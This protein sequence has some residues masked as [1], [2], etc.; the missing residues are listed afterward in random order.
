[1]IGPL[2]ALLFALLVLVSARA[3]CGQTSGVLHIRIVVVDAEQKVTPVSRHTLL[4]SE[5]PPSAAPRAIVT[6][7]DGTAEV[8]LRPGNYTVESERPVAFQGRVYQWTRRIDIAAGGDAVLE[9]TA[10]NADAVDPLAPGASTPA[11][12]LETDPSFLLSRWQGSVVAIWSPTAHASGFVV[13]ARGLIATNQKVIGTATTVEVQ[14][15]PQI[16]IPARVLVAD[17]M[18]DVAV[19]LVNPT[20][21]ASM[22]PMPLGCAQT[23]R[24]AVARDQQIFTI[25]TPLRA[26]K[27]MMSGPVSRVDSQTIVADFRLDSG[28]AGGPVFTAEG[29]VVG[30]TTV[31]A[32][33]DDGSRRVTRAVRLDAVCD[34]VA[35]A[36]MKMAETAPPDATRLPME[37]TRPF[38]VNALKEAAKGRA[39]SLTPPL[40]PSTE[41]DV[42]FITPVLTYAAQTLSSPPLPLRDFSNWSEYVADFPPV[43]LVRVTPKM[44]ESFWTTVARGAAMTQGVALPPIKGFKSGFARLRAFCGDAEVT[45]IHP[46]KLERRVSETE[47]IYEG[48]YVYDPGAL[49]PHCATVKVVLYS[50]KEPEKG[51]TRVVDP[52]VLQR[53]WQD[54]A[55]WRAP[56]A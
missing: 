14:L 34:V 32:D 43:L 35:S 5:N 8:S 42:S 22:R 46:F 31:L 25:G 7:P 30:L 53:I 39:G 52:K 28:S 1:M 9:L 10:D 12:S 38:A 44:V 40:T 27:G 24:P 13:D 29:S 51:D 45:P 41:F 36:D 21:V 33:S 50:D 11:T 17:A 47:A 2:R 18:R 16:K 56:D 48:L 19:L 4:I 55:P 6:G 15:T 49:G 23:P 20:M 3:V 26:Q 37:P 54:F